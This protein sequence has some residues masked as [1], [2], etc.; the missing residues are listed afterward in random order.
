MLERCTATDAR[1]EDL[2]GLHRQ[3]TNDLFRDMVHSLLTLYMSSIGTIY[4]FVDEALLGEDVEAYF[5]LRARPDFD[6]VKLEGQ[7]AYQYFRVTMM[8]AIACSSKS[9]HQPHLLAYGNGFYSEAVRSVE[10]VTSEVSSR[11]LQALLFLAVYCLFSPRKGNV[12]KLLDFVCRLSVQLGYHTEQ[13]SELEDE[14]Q[15]TLRRNTFWALY[16]IERL[17]GQFLGRPSDLP[18]PIISTEHPTVAAISPSAGDAMIQTFSAAHVFRLMYLRSEIYTDVYLPAKPPLHDL[19]WFIDRYSALL[20]WYREVEPFK[21][22]TGCGT[23]TCNVLLHSSIIFLF[24]PLIL[25]ALSHTG[26]STSD[27]APLEAIPS[28]SYYS[29]CELIRIYDKI[30]RASEDSALGIY[31][32]TFLSAYS[33]W[34]AAMTLMAHCLLTMDCRTETL[35]RFPTDSRPRKTQKIDYSDLFGLSGTCLILLA[36]CAEKWPGMEGM[37]D[38]YQ[39]LSEKILPL[40]MQNGH[41]Y[42][43]KA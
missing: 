36:W 19:D 41:V 14:R 9:R 8:C 34:L 27:V 26:S 17:L 7:E 31:P 28:E 23:V 18:E 30:V 25:R 4:P 43:Y 6:S 12:W 33:I 11:S 35:A 29:A 3:R 20:H 24:Q 21:D 5:E 38:A 13:H 22:A 37:R 16:S 39:R 32:M 15:K 10:E 40:L 2:D 42:I 1:F